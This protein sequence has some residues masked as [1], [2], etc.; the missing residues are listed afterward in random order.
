MKLKNRIAWWIPKCAS[1]E[2][3]SD[4]VTVTLIRTT[5]SNA[6]GEDFII[7]DSY[8]VV[9]RQ[10]DVS[11]DQ[12]YTWSVTLCKGRYTIQMM[13]NDYYVGWSSGSNLVIKKGSSKVGTFSCSGKSKTSYFTV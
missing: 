3:P 1:S 10:L 7:Y 12:Q 13:D 4:E 9:F 5:K 8:G 11:S 2:C 6:Y